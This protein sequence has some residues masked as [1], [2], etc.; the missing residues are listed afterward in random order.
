MIVTIILSLFGIILHVFGIY[1]LR[2][3]QR[4]NNNQK[5]ILTNLSIIEILSMIVSAIFRV[6]HFY[7]NEFYIGLTITLGF[8]T[9]LIFVFY[10]SM[11]FIS[12]DRLL[13]SVLHIKYDYYITSKRVKRVIFCI[14]IIALLLSIPSIFSL[15]GCI[16]IVCYHHMPFMLGAVFIIVSISAYASIIFVILKGRKQFMN[17]A[18]TGRSINL[19]MYSVP[20]LI[21]AT[22]IIFHEIPL[23]VF[24]NTINIKLNFLT[25]QP[26]IVY[27]SYIIGF[28]ADAFIYIFIDEKVRK[29]AISIICYAFCTL[30]E[31]NTQTDT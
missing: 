28:I 23:L 15:I 10:L 9:L 8:D 4:R 6:L 12:F 2:K 26:N 11:I 25:L 20:C 18:T 22:F 3:V 30:K 27:C 21:I 19:K 24:L 5:I 31:I 16:N 7:K 1:C 14:W 17:Q 13:C 29:F